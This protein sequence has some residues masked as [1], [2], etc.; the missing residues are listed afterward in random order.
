MKTLNETALRA[1]GEI[2]RVQLGC[3]PTPLQKLSGFEEKTGYDGLFIKRDDL[4][5][6][7]PGGNKV[8]TLEFLLA[9]AKRD[10]ADTVLASG[11]AQSNLCTLAACCAKKLGLDAVLVH[12]AARPKTPNG[13][14]LLNKLV[15]AK[16]VYIGAGTDEFQ[17]ADEVAKIEQT[18]RGE[19]KKPYT[20][21][22]GGST[23]LGAIGYYPVVEE[24]ARQCGENKYDIQH[25]FVPGGNG[26]VAAGM[27][28]ANEI[29]G[30]PF[31][32]HVVSVEDTLPALKEHMQRIIDEMQE[33][34]GIKMPCAIEDACVLTQEF[35]GGG[36]SQN[37]PE[38]IAMVEEFAETEGIYVENVY[39]SKVAV[40]VITAA[41]EKKLQGGICF[42]HT[43]G[44]GSLFAQY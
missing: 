25:V 5:G 30:R 20:V 12:N 28:Y 19:G 42:L 39:T 32:I 43:G 40:A 27:V 6:V 36:W 44:F 15:G 4:N 10:G 41:R 16:S 26:G 33:I 9:K 22:L 8:R 34:V 21:L 14:E 18:L 2:E 29:L 13:N 3:W 7:G 17:R 31:T 23:G 11:P 37:T 24:L 38:S 35:M 1:L